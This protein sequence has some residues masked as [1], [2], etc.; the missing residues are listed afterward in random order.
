MI[1]ASV[2]VF[3]NPIKGARALPTLLA[4]EIHSGGSPF[5]NEA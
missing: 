5:A 4:C 1:N 2:I 3:N